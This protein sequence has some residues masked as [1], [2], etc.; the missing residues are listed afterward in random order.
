MGCESSI[1]CEADQGHAY[2]SKKCAA[3]RTRH[4][5]HDSKSKELP[6]NA[7]SDSDESE[8]TSTRQDDDD[9]DVHHLCPGPTHAKSTCSRSAETTRQCSWCEIGAGD[10]ARTSATSARVPG[11]Y[12]DIISVQDGKIGRRG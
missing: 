5:I 1:R 7:S 12:E 4:E 9:D 2:R 8:K 3:L 10:D 6:E 11:R